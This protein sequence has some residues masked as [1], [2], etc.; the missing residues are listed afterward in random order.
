MPIGT[1]N[2]SWGETP[3]N[4][5][6]WKNNTPTMKPG[7]WVPR[8]VVDVA[9]WT[10]PE[11]LQHLAMKTKRS[12]GRGEDRLEARGFYRGITSRGLGRT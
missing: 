3:R 9:E 5:A 6:E 12:Q 2:Q 8:Q 7:G 4:P 10:L 1:R 11:D